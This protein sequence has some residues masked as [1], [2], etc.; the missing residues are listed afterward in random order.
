MKSIGRLRLPRIDE[1]ASGIS[2]RQ[3]TAERVKP[4]GLRVF[5]KRN[6]FGP[7]QYACSR[8]LVLH[9]ST[10]LPTLVLF[11]SFGF[12]TLILFFS[13]GFP[14]L[15]LI[16]SSAFPALILFFFMGFPTLI[17]RLHR[18]YFRQWR[19]SCRSYPAVPLC[20][21]ASYKVRHGGLFSSQQLNLD[22][23]ALLLFCRRFD[24]TLKSL[25]EFLP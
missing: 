24:P 5:L 15:I 19:G 4:F 1:T 12:P 2:G 20:L 10:R 3:G 25:L 22:H 18:R 16:F 8:F 21:I 13:T 6:L 9:N 7:Q 11:L 14:A 23:S 17:M